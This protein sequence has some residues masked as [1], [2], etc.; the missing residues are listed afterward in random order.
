LAVELFE[1]FGRRLFQPATCTLPEYYDEDL[2]PL[3]GE[4]GR[5]VE[6][7]HHFEWAWLLAWYQRLTGTDV[8]PWAGP[9]TAFAERH[10]VDHDTGAVHAAVRD[11][12]TVLDRSQRV[13]PMTERLQAAV[14]MY[15]LA[16]H[17][18]S[19]AFASTANRLLSRH[20]AHRPAGTWTD[21]HSETGAIMVDKIPA[22]TLYHVMIGFT[23]MLRTG[24]CTGHGPSRASGPERT[25]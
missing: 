5:I 3:A 12:G 22:S 16:G 13:W 20:L 18:P 11:D 8:R 9:L 21:I 17:D 2:R 14:A 24:E 7:G 23:E 4:Q 10:G 19:P 6:P 1:L 15:D 25:G